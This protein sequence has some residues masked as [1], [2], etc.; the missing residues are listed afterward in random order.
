MT[1]LGQLRERVKGHLRRKDATDAQLDEFIGNAIRRAQRV[2]RVAALERAF[3][4]QV[5]YSGGQPIPDY[6]PVNPYELPIP[7]DF[8][9]IIEMRVDDNTIPMVGLREFSL[10]YR[11]NT[12]PKMFTREV[13]QWLISKGPRQGQQIIVLYY[14][15][16]SQFADDNDQNELS[17]FAP[18]LLMWGALSIAGDFFRID[19][20]RGEWE[21]RYTAELE[22]IQTQANAQEMAAIKRVQPIYGPHGEELYSAEAEYR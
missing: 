2:L 10:Q 14:A 6:Q 12:E 22:A 9:E 17:A 15:D 5:G 18:D 4:T 7:G 8:L 11:P 20:R 3:V 1:T 16:A 13:N 21:G 19:D